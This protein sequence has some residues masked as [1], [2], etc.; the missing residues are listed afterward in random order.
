MESFEIIEKT[1][2]NIVPEITRFIES[3]L[4]KNNKC[5]GTKNQLSYCKQDILRDYSCH[6][7]VGYLC[8]KQRRFMRIKRGGREVPVC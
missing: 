2:R 1:K 8:C 4:L 6:D 3:S 7:C 5:R